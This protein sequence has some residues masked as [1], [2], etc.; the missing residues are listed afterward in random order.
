M[1]YGLWTAKPPDLLRGGSLGFFEALTGCNGEFLLLL[2]MLFRHTSLEISLCSMVRDSKVHLSGSHGHLKAGIIVWPSTLI[3]CL[4]H[5]EW[6][7][8]DDLA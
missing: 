3:L 2:R 5:C 6:H 8:R 4:V 7:L 1:C